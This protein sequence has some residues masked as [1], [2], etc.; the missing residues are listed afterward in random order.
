MLFHKT[1]E[2][3]MQKTK[4]TIKASLNVILCIGKTLQQHELGL[5]VQMNKGQLKAIMDVLKES[6]IE[7]NYGSGGLPYL[8]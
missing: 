6:V 2:L 8:G 7:G 1:S 5:T 4:A 3:V